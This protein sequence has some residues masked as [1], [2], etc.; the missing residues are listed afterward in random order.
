MGDYCIYGCIFWSNIII[1]GWG[2]HNHAA[3]AQH[4]FPGVCAYAAVV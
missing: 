1:C 2:C 3:A 4:Y